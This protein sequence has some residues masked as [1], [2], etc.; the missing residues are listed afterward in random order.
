METSKGKADPTQEVQNRLKC[1]DILKN[2]MELLSRISEYC[3]KE[4]RLIRYIP[5]L[6]HAMFEIS[7]CLYISD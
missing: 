4:E 3:E 2:Q 7:R 5:A 6:S 1:T